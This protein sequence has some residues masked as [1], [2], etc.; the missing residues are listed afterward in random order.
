MLFNYSL[1]HIH[2]FVK[3]NYVYLQCFIVFYLNRP[4]DSFPTPTEAE[5]I[6]NSLSIVSEQSQLKYAIVDNNQNIS[7]HSVYWLNSLKPN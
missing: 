4:Q 7:F 5:A 3:F 6:A 2:K 1:N